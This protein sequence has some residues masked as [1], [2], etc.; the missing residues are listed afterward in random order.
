LVLKNPQFKEIKTVA[1]LWSEIARDFY[2]EGNMKK[3]VLFSFGLGVSLFLWLLGSQALAAEP[4]KITFGYSTIGPMAAGLWM[5]TDMGAFEKYGMQ[6]SLIY[7][8]SG[9][10]V[11]QALLGGD[12]HAG[13]AASN[14][15]INAALNRAPIVGIAGTA[16]RPYHRLWVQPE[17]NKIEDLRGKTLG[18]TRYGGLSDNLTQILL[19]KYGLEEAVKIR[20]FGGGTREVAAAFQQRVVQGTV[21]SDLVVDSHVP[22]KILINLVDLGIPYSMNMIVV[23]RDYYNQNRE[24]VGGMIRAYTEGVAALHYQKDRALKILAKYAR[25]E[26][27]KRIEGLYADANAYLERVPRLEKDAIYTILDFMGKKGTHLDTIVDS[28]IV[29]GMVREGFVEKLYKKR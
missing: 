15:V 9:A 25:I 22:A 8:P 27:P 29:D 23:S 20:Q 2:R 4:K 18:V 3:T 24:S 11:M 7:I 10:V 28:S 26:D 16:N 5:A 13:I 19:K 12:L 14:S 1:T 6:A 17:I 21:T